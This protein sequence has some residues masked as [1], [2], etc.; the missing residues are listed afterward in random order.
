MG[1]FKILN[2][3]IQSIHLLDLEDEICLEALF[4]HP[5]MLHSAVEGFVTSL[6]FIIPSSSSHVEHIQL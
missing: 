1:M 6:Q 3:L 5:D 4:I 2:I